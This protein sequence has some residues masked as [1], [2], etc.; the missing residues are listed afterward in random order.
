MKSHKGYFC[1]FPSCEMPVTVTFLCFSRLQEPMARVW[2][3]SI[4]WRH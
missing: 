3:Q 1:S 2:F 4:V